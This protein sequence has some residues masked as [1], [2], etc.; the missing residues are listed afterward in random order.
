MFNYK[1][2]LLD[3]DN[4]LY[5]Y[6]QCHMLGLKK[7]IDYCHN[8]AFCD[9]SQFETHFLF[10]RK[11]VN[12]RLHNT[13]SSHNRM[14]YFQ[15][16][17]ER[18][19]INPLKHTLILYNLYWDAFLENMRL[20]D[21]ALQFVKNNSFRICYLTD[22]T[23]HIQHR[24]LNVLGLM[25]FGGHLVTSEE[26]GVEKPNSLIFELALLKLDLKPN[27]VCMI[28]DNFE[29]DIKGAIDLGIDAFWKCEQSIQDSSENLEYTR[30]CNFNELG[31]L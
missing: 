23:A 29:K 16:L 1:G 12:K 4:T 7:V 25:D 14:L 8:H 11:I 5:D 27:E 22:L 6:D 24:K 30:F 3:I 10:S 19:G 26:A 21:G 17:C 18:L 9:Q 13:A 2:I 15:G 28:G 20:F 31:T